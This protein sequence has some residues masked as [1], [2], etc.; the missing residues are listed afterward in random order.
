MSWS[1]ST[2][3]FD[4]NHKLYAIHLDIVPQDIN[5]PMLS[6]LNDAMDAAQLL[7]KSIPGPKVIVTLSGHANGVGW[8]K[9]DGW[10]DDCITV[11]V[12]QVTE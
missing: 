4:K 11:T 10:V 3:P 1:A 5:G 8:N 2:L 9:K 12:R 6:Q 7:I